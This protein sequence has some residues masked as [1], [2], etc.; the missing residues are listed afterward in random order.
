MLKDWN[1]IIACTFCRIQYLHWILEDGVK[2]MPCP[3]ENR[4]ILIVK[5]SNRAIF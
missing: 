4:L 5:Y 2:E 3:P 1:R